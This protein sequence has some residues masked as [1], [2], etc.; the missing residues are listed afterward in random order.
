M[1]K[2]EQKTFVKELIKNVS[3][4]ILGKVPLF[5]DRWDGR[6]LRMYIAD[7]FGDCVMNGTTS[8]GIIKEYKNT[9]TITNL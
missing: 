6:Q 2:Q 7:K 4:D 5:P 8:R 9:R 3:S 1:T